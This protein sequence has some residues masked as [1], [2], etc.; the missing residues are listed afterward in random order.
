MIRSRRPLSRARRL[1][2]GVTL[3]V[4]LGVIALTGAAYTAT[5]QTASTTISAGGTSSSNLFADVYT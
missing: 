1:V 5:N 3:A 4:G 2:L